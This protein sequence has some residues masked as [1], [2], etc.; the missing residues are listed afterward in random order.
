MMRKYLK[1]AF[2]AVF[3]AAAAGY[4]VSASASQKSYTMSEL[5]L[6]NVEALV[7]NEVEQIKCNEAMG[8]TCILVNNTPIAGEKYN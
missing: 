2:V 4:G 3:V 6:A 1:F 7:R 5:A 8:G